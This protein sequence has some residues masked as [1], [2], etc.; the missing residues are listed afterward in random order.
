VGPCGEKQGGRQIETAAKRCQKT[1]GGGG[2]GSEMV[3]KGRWEA[4][5]TD[6]KVYKTNASHE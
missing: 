5:G 3:N 1:V 4:G 2:M 6:S